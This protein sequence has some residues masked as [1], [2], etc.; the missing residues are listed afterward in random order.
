MHSFFYFFSDGKHED[1]ERL[2]FPHCR[3]ELKNWVIHRLL[4][5]F[6]KDS[7]ERGALTPRDNWFCGTLGSLEA[8]LERR[9]F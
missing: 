4:R 6:W 1:M 9:G 5:V 7:G 3:T 2:L 8:R